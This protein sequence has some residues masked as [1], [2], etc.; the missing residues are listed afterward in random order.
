MMR[1]ALT[2]V[3]GVGVIG[4]LSGCHPE[5][6]RNMLQCPEPWEPEAPTCDPAAGRLDDRCDGVF[7]SSASGSDDNTG[8]QAQPV[9]TLG[10][11]L[12]A[13]QTGPRRVYACAE[14][15]V[16]AIELPTGVELWGGLD[17][18]GGWRYVG[19]TS[20]TTIAPEAGM[21]PLR[22]MPGVGTAIVADVRAQA[23]D[24]TQPSGSSIAALVN[25]DAMVEI[26][27]SELVAGHGAA[28]VSPGTGG[29]FPAEAGAP[30]ADG[31]AACSAGVVAGGP[32]T[33]QTCRGVDSIG[34]QGG[35]GGIN[36]GGSGLQGQPE[37]FP[38]PQGSGLGG[39]GW[40]NGSLCDD[41]QPGAWGA[42]GAQGAG[43]KGG[44][45]ITA[46]G[47]EGEQGQDGGDG[48]PGQGGG[49]GGGSRGGAMFCGAAPLG[50]A[51][52]GGGGTGG[53]GGT[54][55]KGGGYGGASI[56]LLSLSGGVTIRST[57]I[58]TSRGGDGGSGGVGQLGGQGGERG[59]GGQGFNLSP[60]G[61]FGGH[62]G[63][64]GDGGH[65]GGGLGGPSVGI[66][67]SAGLAPAQES[68]YIR[69]DAAGKGG[70]GGN[71]NIP[72]SSGA[73]G[74]RSDVL[75]FPP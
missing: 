57:T 25:P 33:M 23:A 10:K 64:G 71:P 24:A 1:T 17:C 36:S 27:R 7:V 75:G 31:G 26:V 32:P 39:T 59:S 47:W 53:C 30:G 9:R 65:G 43:A 40:S 66:L 13:A 52:G 45:R 67:H 21:I 60:P 50:G 55:A 58:T 38:N 18:T 34:A 20:K 42:N 5:D 69:T 4:G 2:L 49:G 73:D 6:C 35:Y 54:G 74:I 41:G 68:V 51:S 8:T 72:G 14:V 22:V 44:G 29:Q 3:L 70:F 11:A 19:E 15:F 62:G 48:L 16:E 56:G 63:K 37:P 46:A 61:C 12:A 28:G